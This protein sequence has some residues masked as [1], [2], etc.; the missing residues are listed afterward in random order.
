[1][2]SGTRPE[3]DSKLD[4]IDR[5]IGCATVQPINLAD[6]LKVGT[7]LFNAP[8]HDLLGLLG[9]KEPGV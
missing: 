3:T 4:E 1:M 7:C 2:E 8:E 5:A 9:G 6:Y